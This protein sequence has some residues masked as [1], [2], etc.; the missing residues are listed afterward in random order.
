MKTAKNKKML[1]FIIIAVA[2]LLVIAACLIIF[3]RNKSGN[4]IT[5]VR[6]EMESG[7]TFV[8]ELYPEYAPKTVENFIRLV[9]EGFY[10]GLMFHRVVDGFMAQ[11]GSPNGDGIGGSGTEIK[12]E[13]S[14]NGFTQNTLKH[15]KGVISMARGDS[16]DSASSQFFIM[17]DTIESLDGLYAAFGKV[18][19]GMEVIEAFQQVERTINSF[20]EI[21]IPVE[22]LV[23]KTVEVIEE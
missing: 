8:I 15:T 4:S 3:M 23:M 1:L 9:N 14:S 18:I 10:D 6:V 20:G 5:K 12:G 19:E 11:G 13:F 21:A 16:P 17:Y 7:E 2:A 22:P